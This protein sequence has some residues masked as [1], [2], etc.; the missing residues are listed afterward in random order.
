MVSIWL[1]IRQARRRFFKDWRVMLLALLAL[2]VGIGGNATI[3]SVANGVLR[4]PLPYPQPEQLTMVWLDNRVLSN[5]KDL[6]SYPNF[7]DWRD[8]NTT[9]QGMA[10][11]SLWIPGLSGVDE[12]Q[13]LNGAFVGPE[14]FTVLGVEPVLGRGFLEA[15]FQPGN[16]AHVVLSHGLW[17][18]RFGG[19][20]SILGRTVLLE[21]EPYEVVG[22]MPPGFDF[23][24]DTDVWA[25]LAPSDRLRTERLGLLFQV[26]GRLKPS[27]TVEQAQADLDVVAKRLEQEYPDTNAGFGVT[28]VSLRDQLTGEFKPALLV[29]LGAVGL[30]LLIACGNVASLLLSRW[31]G[32]QSEFAVR[33]AMGASSPLLVRQLLTESLLLALVGGVAGLGLSALGLRVVK[34][35]GSSLIPHLEDVQIQPEALVFT[36]LVSVFAALIAGLAPALWMSSPEG[37]SASLGQRA[38]SFVGGSRGRRLLAGFIIA[39]V[40]LALVLLVGAGLLLQTIPR[41]LKS[42]PGFDPNNVL[43]MELRLSRN[44]YPGEA[45]LVGFSERLVQGLQ[46]L[47]GVE[48]AALA[49]AVPLKGV[50]VSKGLTIEGRPPQDL[51]ENE[52]PVMAVT[53]HYLDTM[54]I[55]L[56]SGQTFSEEVTAG[57]RVA[58][59]NEVMAKLYWPQGDPVGKRL[60][61]VPDQDP[62]WITIVGVVGNVRRRALDA[63]PRPEIYVPFRQDPRRSVK[64]VLRAHSDP[65]LLAPGAREQVWA[66]DRSLPIQILTMQDLMLESIAARRVAM[67]CLV[68]IALI[69]LLLAVTGIYGVVSYAVRQS[70]PEIGIRLALG[71]RRLDILAQVLRR[72]GALVGAGLVLGLLLAFAFTRLLSTLLYGVAATDLLT[73]IGVTALL[74]VVGLIAGYLPARRAA[75]VDPVVAMRAE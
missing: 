36:F 73:F 72:A 55:P 16:D 66:L 69:A 31:T 46:N 1:D 29:L 57:R 38:S 17:Q 6:T 8:Q 24:D 52:T 37:V 4:R 68:L 5:K 34:G 44:H 23:P 54:K 53:D 58:L 28:V 13:Y 26:V 10:A 32:R 74:A 48:S 65:W 30:V 7:V 64:I 71:A 18:R 63:D 49:S 2:A 70:T 45:D 11:F 50:L 60:R 51:Q 75:R 3:F 39:E 67:T 56:L 12:P 22:V 35:V 27:A 20:R 14:L 59:I 15:E 62:S 41:L 61:L 21:A 43:L 47:P 25:P 42:A 9:Y 19:D 33:S 40:A